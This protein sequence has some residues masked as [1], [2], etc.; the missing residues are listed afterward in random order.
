MRVRCIAWYVI[1]QC[2]LGD[3]DEDHRHLGHDDDDHA[4]KWPNLSIWAGISWFAVKASCC[5]ARLIWSLHKLDNIMTMMTRMTMMML[6]MRMQ[7][8]CCPARGRPQLHCAHNCHHTWP[9]WGE[10]IIIV[11]III[12]IVIV[13][14]MNMMIM[15]M[16]RV[17][18]EYDFEI[19]VSQ[20]Q[21]YSCAKIF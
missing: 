1:Y 9:G 4:G 21:L 15:Q 20:L 13:I 8:S 2:E 6:M 5:P 17:T 14:I 16:L 10:I 7:A 11:V 18:S 12:I 19:T 3:D